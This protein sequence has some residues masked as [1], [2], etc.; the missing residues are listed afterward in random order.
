MK[1]GDRG[2][3]VI[4]RPENSFTWDLVHKFGGR[5]CFFYHS[6]FQWLGARYIHTIFFFLLLG[7]WF[8]QR[9][10]IVLITFEAI[11]KICGQN[12]W[13]N[14][15][16]AVWRRRNGT[17]HGKRVRMNFLTW[18]MMSGADKEP[19]SERKWIKC[20][21]ISIWYHFG[22]VS[23]YFFFFFCFFVFSFKLISVFRISL[24]SA[25]L[26]WRLASGDDHYLWYA[27]SAMHISTCLCG[28]CAVLI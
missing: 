4:N 9:I 20:G 16:P 21:E 5:G 23:L 24:R 28:S 25:T 6:N 11:I 17:A 10:N 8:W 2:N 3:A 18:F 1:K 27:D 26:W 12:R 7:D 19:C 15:R 13:L 22:N 14:A